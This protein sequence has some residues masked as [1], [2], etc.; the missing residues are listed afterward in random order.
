MLTALVVFEVEFAFILNLSVGES[1]RDK[2]YFKICLIG[3]QM[4]LAFMIF[5]SM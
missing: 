1:K 4:Q 2:L 3:R 5:R